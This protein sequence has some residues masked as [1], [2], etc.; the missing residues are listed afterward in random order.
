MLS[1]Y[2]KDRNSTPKGEVTLPASSV[3][4][5]ILESLKLGCLRYVVL[6]QVLSQ[7]EL[8]E[9][10]VPVSLQLSSLCRPLSADRCLAGVS[11]GLE[12]ALD[13]R[14]SSTCGSD[15]VYQRFLDRDIYAHGADL[16][17]M[18][19]AIGR[20]PDQYTVFNVIQS[21]LYHPEWQGN[22]FEQRCQVG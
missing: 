21:R 16:C 4:L 5:V 14:H 1:P 3:L 11:G 9:E 13:P 20:T 18:S 2:S 10:I 6:R 15:Q 19:G 8:S 22:L 12:L 7:Q 17:D